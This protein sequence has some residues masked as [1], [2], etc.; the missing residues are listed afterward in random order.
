VEPGPELLDSGRDRGRVPLPRWS[1]WLLVPLAVVLV[2]VGLGRAGPVEPVR[3]PDP[4]ALPTTP[5]TALPSAAPAPPIA[6]TTLGHSLLGVTAGWELFGRGAEEVVR[7]ELARGRITRT[8]VAPLLS[9]APVSFVVGPDRAVVRSL[10]QVPGYVVPDGLPARP[11]PAGLDGGGVAFPGPTPGT[12]WVEGAATMVLRGMADGRP[13]WYVPVPESTPEISA[14]GA[15]GIVFRATGGVYAAT[16]AGLRRITTGALLAAGPSRWLTLDCDATHRCR[17]Y[18]ID[19]ATGARRAVPAVL[20]ADVPRGLVAPNGRTAALF[21]LR[22]D[23]TPVPY[24]L[25]LSTGASLPVGVSIDPPS[26]DNLV[27]SP[28]SRWLFTTA[29]TGMVSAIDPA[30]GAATELGVA[31]T[32]PGQLAVRPG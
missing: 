32:T 17:P 3:A 13:R 6:V 12:V 9:G 16:P 5:P 2:A 30:T 1:R 11:L 25:D 14:D 21:R 27:W 31:L 19:R 18:A 24:L 15:G 10:D 26:E 8:A 7:I 4:T 20:S 28:D 22:R 23:G 29:D